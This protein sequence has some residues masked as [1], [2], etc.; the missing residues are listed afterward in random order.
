[1]SHQGSI[2]NSSSKSRRDSAVFFGF[3]A[4]LPTED[5]TRRKMIRRS[6]K[7]L[8][9][10]EQVPNIFKIFSETITPFTLIICITSVGCTLLCY[11][12]NATFEMEFGIINVAVIFP[13]VFSI[14]EAFRRREQALSHLSK[15]KSNAYSIRFAHYHF[16]EGK[17]LNTIAPMEIDDILRRLFALMSAYFQSEDFSDREYMS[18]LQIFS[19]ISWSIEI[20]LRHGGVP[21]PNISRVNES[22]RSLMEEFEQLRNIRMYRTPIALRAYT[23][24]FV[25]IFPALYSPLFAFIAKDTGALWGS[26]VMVVLYSFILTGLDRIQDG[27]EQPFDGLSVDDVCF[28]EYSAHIH[29][30][31]ITPGLNYLNFNE[32]DEYEVVHPE[33][34]SPV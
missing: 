24:I 12:Y 23:K 30:P 1:M 13:L 14:N 32:N 17:F 34:Q 2:G 11:Y 16:M 27:L 9:A 22:L 26:I 5:G 3:S 20:H 7:M 21:A 15:L 29:F 4:G 6:S 8:V 19:S 25:T 31:V 18:I 28:E 10:R 33:D